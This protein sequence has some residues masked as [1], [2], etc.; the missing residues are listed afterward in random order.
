VRLGRLVECAVRGELEVVRM[1]AGPI[2][3]P[4]GR[5]L[6]RG[7]QR[8]LILTGDLVTSRLKADANHRRTDDLQHS[9]VL[10]AGR[11]T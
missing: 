4:I 5:E 8:F 11:S 7:R 6:P 10:T 1:S 3:W 9:R 2:P